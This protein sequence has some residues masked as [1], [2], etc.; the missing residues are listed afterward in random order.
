MANQYLPGV[1]AIPSSLLL[2]AITR[3]YPM[4]VTV[5]VG[6]STTE[7][8]TYIE[9]MCVKLFVPKTYGMYQAN[10]LTGTILAISGSDFTLDLNST[11]FDIF[12]IPS[13]SVEK[14]ASLS[15]NGSRN[16][17]YSNRTKNVPF[18]SL[19]NIGK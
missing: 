12:S 15:P 16:L 14:P 8:N 9:G 10:G 17:Q 1:I 11:Y 2:T 7:A 18:Q 4:Q 5:A 6:D 3:S 13:G 19:N